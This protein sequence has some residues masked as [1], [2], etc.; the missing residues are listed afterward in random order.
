[1]EQPSLESL[2]QQIDE[3]KAEQN[4]ESKKMAG[5]KGDEKT[6]QQEKIKGI[7]TKLT[8]AEEQ[9][10]KLY[11]EEATASKGAAK[12]AANKKQAK[13]AQGKQQQQPAEA[14]IDFENF[15]CPAGG[16]LPIH[17]SAK[18]DFRTW[19]RVSTLNATSDNTTVWIRAR[20]QTIRPQGNKLVFFALRQKVH[21]IQAL[22]SEQEG[23]AVTRPMLKWAAK[24]S[25]ESIVNVKG[26]VVKSPEPIKTCTQTEVEIQVHELWLESRAT[27]DQ[28][29]KIAD[30]ARPVKDIQEQ[31]K[32]IKAI[33]KKIDDLRIQ[34]PA[35]PKAKAA[36]DSEI[37]KL[38]E[39]KS[40]ATTYV[41][42]KI[43][44][45]LDNRILDLRTTTNQA[46]FRIQSGVGALFRE[47]LYQ[48]NFTEIH[49]PKLI[50]TA[51]EGGAEVFKVQYFSGNAYLAQSPQL[52]KQ[53]AICSDFERVFEI[54][55]VFRAESA[56]TARHLTEFVGL[57]IEMQI[58]DH[59]HEVLDV[60]DNMFFFIFQGLETRYAEE[61]KAIQMQFPF[62]PIKYRNPSPRL[63]FSEGM[64][65]LK[66]ELGRL[67][68]EIA[69]VAQSKNG[70]TPEATPALEQQL[71]ELQAQRTIVLGSD[72]INELDEFADLTTPQE[73]LL[74]TLVKAKYGVDFYFLEK[75]PIAARPFYTMVDPNDPRYTNSYDMFI[76]N[77]EICSGGQRVHDPEMLI[78]R[79]ES[80]G[81][82]PKSIKD[83]IDAF[84][85][86]APPHGGGGVGLERVVML[87]L[88]LKNIRRTSLFPRDPN[89][90]AP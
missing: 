16:V 58:H 14:A 72:S 80:K 39:E 79:A 52:Y 31:K 89:R 74:G 29:L 62:E 34:V 41:W 23:L 7:K 20:V 22:L 63:H 66:E 77:E 56:F 71:S 9:L 60:M 48:N 27:S 65:L 68:G 61:I 86:G 50:S 26:R 2:K 53:M 75:Y 78:K 30:C 45:R 1:M 25:D 19:T 12:K 44:T 17:Q 33:E 40:R 8:A 38:V 87:Y 24:I 76:R 18:R 90:L 32:K 47:Y 42:P 59:Y 49:T 55:P 3:L 4:A 84:R 36:N 10:K 5:L 28:P 15:T 81:V 11:P 85:F 21:T 69:K 46:I 35:D 73:K 64:S 6:A 70:A 51:S 57:D 54:G 82:P 43:N 83:Y 88:N 13:E 37:E 67:N